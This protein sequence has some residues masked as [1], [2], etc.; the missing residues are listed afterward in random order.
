MRDI[1]E[2]STMPR[3]FHTST[4]I[5][6]L[7]TFA[8]VTLPGCDADDGGSEERKLEL[9][10]NSGDF[11]D[12]FEDEDEDEEERAGEGVFAARR[13]IPAEAAASM[14][15][16]TDASLAPQ[17]HACPYYLTYEPSGF[18]EFGNDVAGWIGA[19]GE[20]FLVDRPSWFT[21][22][23]SVIILCGTTQSPH[24]TWMNVRRNLGATVTGCVTSPIGSP[25]AWF[26]CS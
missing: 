26:V 18:D 11:E 8:L 2:E 4:A 10:E 13:E 25:N 9:V 17:F 19:Q 7:A 12:D 14:K 22:G 3:T 20:A 21:L 5:S 15:A 24:T 1:V 6:L 23:G 16:A